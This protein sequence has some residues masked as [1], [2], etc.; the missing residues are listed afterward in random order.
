MCEFQA[1]ICFLLDSSGSIN[2]LDPNNWDRVKS[3]VNSIVDRLDI[4]MEK[5]RVGVVTFSTAA[6]K[7]IFLNEYY[8]K[9]ALQNAIRNLQYEGGTTNTSGGLWYM[10]TQCFSRANGD[11]PSVDN[12]AIIITDGKSTVDAELTIPYAQQARYEG[13]RII[14]VG[15]TN[16]INM[17]ELEAI[18]SPPTNGFKTVITVDDFN[19]LISFLTTL[20]EY[21]CVTRPTT[22]VITTPALNPIL[23]MYKCIRWWNA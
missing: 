18:A 15:I 21:I 20:I 14:G 4:G 16:Q 8:E 23:G 5:T 1:D 17:E 11:R 7:G 2:D 22:T 10:R 6:R 13:I 12:T 9:S 19:A 3:F